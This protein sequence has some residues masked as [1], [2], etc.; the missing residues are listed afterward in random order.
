MSTDQPRFG[1][2]HPTV[3][4]ANFEA[5]EGREPTSDDHENHDTEESKLDPTMR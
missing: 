5:V 1:I 3:V 4:P 2:D